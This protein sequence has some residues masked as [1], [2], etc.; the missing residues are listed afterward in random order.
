MDQSLLR[1]L[2]LVGAVALAALVGVIALKIHDARVRRDALQTMQVDSLNR[3]IDSSRALNSRLNAENK[4]AAD[5]IVVLAKRAGSLTQIASELRNQADSLTVV[6]SNELP[7]CKPAIEAVRNSY[8]QVIAVKDS[9]IT[10]YTVTVALQATQLRNDSTIIFGYQTQLQKAIEQRDA[11]QHE[12]HPG[13]IRQVSNALPWMAGAF[14]LAK[15][16]K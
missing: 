16:S 5:S 4:R 1:N 2:K 7:D 11:F 9:I 12:A 3:V 10:V 14:L 8:T 13:L 15:V 6:L